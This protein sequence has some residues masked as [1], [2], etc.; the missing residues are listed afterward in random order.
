MIFKVVIYGCRKVSNGTVTYLATTVI[1]DRNLFY[2]IGL[3]KGLIQ[4]NLR[5]I[6]SMVANKLFCP[7]L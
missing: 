6:S 1:Y 5:V 3:G 7:R 2:Y 4:R